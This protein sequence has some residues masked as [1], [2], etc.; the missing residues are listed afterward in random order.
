MFLFTPAG[1]YQN[2]QVDSFLCFLFVCVCI[3]TTRVSS[4]PGVLPGNVLGVS[5]HIPVFPVELTWK[6]DGRPL[7]KDRW[8]TETSDEYVTS[9]LVIRAAR[10]SDSGTYTCAPARAAHADVQVH[11]ISGEWGGGAE[12]QGAQGSKVMSRDS[13]WVSHEPLE[14]RRGNNDQFGSFSANGAPCG[15]FREM[16]HW[17]RWQN[18]MLWCWTS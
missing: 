7:S 9:R 5:D 4:C 18:D 2:M 11:V 1:A 3:F 6:L 15:V 14:S 8:V 12:G 16:R 10:D 13:C 17:I